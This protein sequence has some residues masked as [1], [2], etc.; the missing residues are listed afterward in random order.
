MV[1]LKEQL[2]IKITFLNYIKEG[3]EKDRNWLLAEVEE[4]I[5]ITSR[6]MLN[7]MK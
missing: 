4:L 7:K 6:M 1:N 3:N 2:P 5:A